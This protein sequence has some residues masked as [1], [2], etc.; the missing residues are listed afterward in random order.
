MCWGYDSSRT[1]KVRLS[2]LVNL[3]VNN[4]AM[5]IRYS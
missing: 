4:T 3:N 2:D 5:F 1:V